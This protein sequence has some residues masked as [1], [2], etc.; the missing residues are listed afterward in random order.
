[1][2][3]PMSLRADTAAIIRLAK[4][5]AHSRKPLLHLGNNRHQTRTTAEFFEKRPMADRRG[6]RS[7][8]TRTRLLVASG[9]P[10]H[11]SGREISAPSQVYC[12]GISQPGGIAGLASNRA[13]PSLRLARAPLYR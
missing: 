9:I 11:V 1:M 3:G 4:F 10:D 12:A 6:H 5:F 13:R 2:V 7:S 8:T